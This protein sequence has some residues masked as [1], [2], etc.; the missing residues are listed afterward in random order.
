MAGAPKYVYA[1]LTRWGG[2]GSKEAKPGTL[3]GVL[4][5][6]VGEWEW[7]HM[8]R[9][10]PEVIHVHCVTV[11]PNDPSVLLAGTHDG[12]F[13]STDRGESWHRLDFEPRDLQVWSICYHPENPEIVLA[14]TSPV[15]IYRS[16]DGGEHWQPAAGSQAPDNLDVGRFVNRVMRIAVDPTHPDDIYAAMEVNGALRSRD[17]GQSWEDCTATLLQLGERPELHS[18]VLTDDHREG[19]LDAHAICTSAAL[20]RTPVI[21]LRMG[22]FAGDEGGEA[23]R[24]MGVGRFSPLTYARDVRVAP[25]NPDVLYACLSDSSHGVTGSLC[26]SEDAG[27]SWARIDHSVTPET[28]AMAVALD[29]DDPDLVFFTTRSGQVF[30]TT[31]GGKT[32]REDLLPQGCTGVYALACA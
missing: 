15:G 6:Q 21:A 2:G 29:T 31:D 32:W 27:K 3:G 25:Q 11:H 12:P 7:R 22:L 18:K 10:F 30:G 23:W 19:M 20:P 17:R 13:R 24:D 28:P 1:G 14:G 5:M 16:D 26:R 8:V 4:R 9:G